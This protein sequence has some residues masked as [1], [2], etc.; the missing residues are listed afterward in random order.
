MN[1]INQD[2]SFLFLSA[3]VFDNEYSRVSRVSRR[4]LRGPFGQLLMDEMAKTDRSKTVGDVTD[5]DSPDRVSLNE[6]P[7]LDQICSQPLDLLGLSTMSNMPTITSTAGSDMMPVI[8]HQRTKSS[9][10]KL[11]F[12]PVVK[13][14]EHNF[15]SISSD[16]L[17]VAQ[18]LLVPRNPRRDD[19][20]IGKQQTVGVPVPGG[21]LVSTASFRRPK[22]Q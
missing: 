21:S 11:D 18:E 4:Q 15:A 20:V 10:S 8:S 7:N 6:S 1:I 13:T 12:T 5:V 2:D 14:P 19:S 17:T 9:P 16:K 3:I 22:V